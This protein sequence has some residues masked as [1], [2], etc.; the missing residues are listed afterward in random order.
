VTPHL[1]NIINA[2]KTAGRNRVLK[3]V[4][5]EFKRMTQLN[6]GSGGRYRS[7]TWAP[8]SKEYA[9]KIGTTQATDK[10]SGN[11]YSSIKVGSPTNNFIA[12]YTRNP[13]AA[14]I[15]FGNSKKNLPARNYWPIEIYGRPTFGKL[16]LNADRD[17]FYFITRRFNIVSN[18]AL[19]VFQ[20]TQRATMNIGSPFT[21]ASKSI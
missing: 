4:G 21:G 20:M 11:L 17:M 10:R 5:N 15:A 8:L 3:D 7:K 1:N 13:Y 19:P 6:F 9:K 16:V 18:G 2:L 12:I 14:A